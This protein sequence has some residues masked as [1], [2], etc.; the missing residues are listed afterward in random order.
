MEVLLE[1][2]VML[3]PAAYPAAMASGG[4]I[5]ASNSIPSL[6]GEVELDVKASV[7]AGVL[8]KAG[9]IWKVLSMVAIRPDLFPTQV[10]STW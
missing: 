4:L 8:M 6:I 7:P 2:C 1:D 10:P 9:R 3:S 5:L